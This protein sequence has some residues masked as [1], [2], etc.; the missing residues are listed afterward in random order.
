MNQFN[1]QDY[2]RMAQKHPR[3]NYVSGPSNQKAVRSKRPAPMIPNS[4]QYDRETIS[5]ILEFQ[6][7]VKAT[8][9]ESVELNSKIEEKEN[10]VKALAREIRSIKQ[11]L[12]EIQSEKKF[13][14]ESWEK[15]DQEIE[16]D[17]IE[18]SQI[19]EKV[20]EMRVKEI[21]LQQAKN[22]QFREQMYQYLSGL[23]EFYEQSVSA[24][25]TNL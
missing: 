7:L 11:E 6:S 1:Y 19:G 20:A 12:F 14:K 22:E 3:Q 8:Q 16:Q 18:K 2:P 24:Y 17:K 5:R 15:R 23:T 10:K 4:V 13:L 9:I 21:D 25:Q